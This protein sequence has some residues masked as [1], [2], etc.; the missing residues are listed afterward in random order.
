MTG[1]DLIRVAGLGGVILIAAAL[2]AAL[3]AG[4]RR[5]QR[6]RHYRPSRLLRAGY[7]LGDAATTGWGRL[8]RWARQAWDSFRHDPAWA[9]GWGQLRPL[10]AEDQQ[11]VTWVHELNT[12][13]DRRPAACLPAG[14]LAAKVAAARWLVRAAEAR[15][16]RPWADQTGAFSRA[17][18][19]DRLRGAA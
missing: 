11:T 1:P 13:P 7:R 4:E 19:D 15:A 6:A 9:G 18:L 2:C 12:G 3:I 17:V 8:R 10:P 16:T 14:A 5:Q